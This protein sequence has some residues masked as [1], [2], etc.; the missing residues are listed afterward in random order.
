M[1]NGLFLY[2]VGMLIITWLLEQRTT[3]PSN[4]DVHVGQIELLVKP[5][6]I[7]L[8]GVSPPNFQ[9]IFSFLFLLI[10]LGE[11]KCLYPL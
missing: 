9:N 2:D 8:S 10:Y 1:I 3:K 7:C 6:S 5:H 11:K 4:G